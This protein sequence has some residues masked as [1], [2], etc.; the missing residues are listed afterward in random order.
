MGEWADSI[1]E[2]A[3]CE[4]CGEHIGDGDGFPTLCANCSGK[5][6]KRAKK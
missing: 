1:L 4:Q 3:F 6:K 5:K 2:G